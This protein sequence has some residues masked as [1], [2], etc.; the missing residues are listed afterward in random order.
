MEQETKKKIT[1]TVILLNFI[2]YFTLLKYYI[3]N[4]KKI[5]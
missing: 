5:K 4:S 2:Y 1:R 3:F